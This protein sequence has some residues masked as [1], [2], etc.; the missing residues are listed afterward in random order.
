[1]QNESVK[2]L[3]YFS[4]KKYVQ[5]RQKWKKSSCEELQDRERVPGDWRHHSHQCPPQKR[6]CKERDAIQLLL[7][8][9]SIHHWGIKD[10][11]ICVDV[12]SEWGGQRGLFIHVVLMFAVSANRLARAVM[13]PSAG[14]VSAPQ[15]EVKEQT[16]WPP[17]A[18]WCAGCQKPAVWGWNA[19]R[20]TWCTQSV[21]SCTLHSLLALSL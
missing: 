4:W 10:F 14:H 7:K 9:C 13:G 3:N 21:L 5:T 15:C 16:T 18:P 12:I 19:V 11:T 20:P 1:M 17:A 6:W 2:R 8:F